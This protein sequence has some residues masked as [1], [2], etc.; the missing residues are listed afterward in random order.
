M[1]HRSYYHSVGPGAEKLLLYTVAIV[2]RDH[3]A[4][5]SK[6]EQA[7]LSGEFVYLGRAG[8]DWN[9]MVYLVRPIYS[10]SRRGAGIKQRTRYVEII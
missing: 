6:R 5:N 4:V 8:V 7:N 9:K 2:W 10:D 1:A 3:R